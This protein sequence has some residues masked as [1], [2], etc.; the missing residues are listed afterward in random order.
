MLVS[1][2]RGQSFS[3]ID[4][5]H[6]LWGGLVHVQCRC[7]LHIVTKRACYLFFLSS[8]V[9]PQKKIMILSSSLISPFHIFSSS[10][11]TFCLNYETKR[12]LKLPYG[13]SSCRWAETLFVYG[14]DSP[15]APWPCY[16]FW[17][18]S[19]EW[20]FTSDRALSWCQ[21]TW[22]FTFFLKLKAVS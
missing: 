17:E 11:A 16:P 12:A 22:F 2:E 18:D 5:I 21:Q 10:S 8:V 1:E 9:F 4:F 19:Q 14:L 3:K 7:A 15:L 6:L 20:Y 13:C